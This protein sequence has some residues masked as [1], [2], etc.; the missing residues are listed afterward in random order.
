[1]SHKININGTFFNRASTGYPSLPVEFNVDGGFTIGAFGGA[2]DGAPNWA[3]RLEITLAAA[4]T[5]VLDL[6]TLTNALGAMETMVEF[7]TL[8]C[9]VSSGGRG[10]VTKGASDPFTGFGSNYTLPFS[11]KCPLVIGSDPGIAVS[12]T[13]KN[14]LITNTGAASATFT[15]YLLARK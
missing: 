14:V 4:G 12:N 5:Q 1:M 15:A 10:S 9:T 3:V 6:Y 2:A 11:A 7:H 8:I 13:D